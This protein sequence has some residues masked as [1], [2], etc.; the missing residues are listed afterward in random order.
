MSEEEAKPKRGPG[1]PRKRK[2]RAYKRPEH[3]QVMLHLKRFEVASN[4]VVR[5]PERL[6]DMDAHA[7]SIAAILNAIRDWS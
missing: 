4:R 2:P 6:A 7:D 5:Q 1:R 3:D